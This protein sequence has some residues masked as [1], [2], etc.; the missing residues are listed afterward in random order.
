[1][2]LLQTKSWESINNT[3]GVKFRASQEYWNPTLQANNHSQRMQSILT[4]IR[5][6]HLLITSVY[7]RFKRKNGD[8]SC[9][10]VFARS[11]VIPKGM[12]QPRGEL[13]AALTNAY[14]GEVVKR[15]FKKL[16]KQAIKFTDS[17]VTLFWISNDE[18]PLKQCTRNRVI[19]IQRFTNKEQWMYF[20]SEDMI[21]DIGTR[22]GVLLADVNQDS[23]WVNGYLWM[24][25]GSSHF[26]MLSVNEIKLNEEERK[27]FRKGVDVHITREY[28]L[29]KNVKDRFAF[30]NYQ[31]QSMV[32]F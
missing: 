6:T 19:E 16:H 14:T 25:L 26:P 30:S 10:L 12:T 8:Y 3:V 28:D 2:F 29:S 9:Q 21:A 24:K 23:T 31:S 13:Y 20:E 17:Q 32:I 1:M 11:R 15:S 4:S 18:K 7:V 27:E 5:W 22:K